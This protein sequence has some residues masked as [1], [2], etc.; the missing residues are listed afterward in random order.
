MIAAFAMLMSTS[1][2]EAELIIVRKEFVP[3]EG[4]GEGL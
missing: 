4:L 2:K 1:T 3:G